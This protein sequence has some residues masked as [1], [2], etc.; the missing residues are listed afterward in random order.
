MLRSKTE[1][2]HSTKKPRHYNAFWVLRC[3]H[4]AKKLL[5]I[6]FE[7]NKDPIICKCYCTD[8]ILWFLIHLYIYLFTVNERVVSISERATTRISHCDWISKTRTR[9]G[10]FAERA[11][12][13]FEPNIHTQACH[14]VTCRIMHY[15]GYCQRIFLTKEWLDFVVPFGSRPTFVSVTTMIR[16]R[17]ST[18]PSTRVLPFFHFR[19]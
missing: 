2:V 7:L 19:K 17:E 10:S 16:H 12:S 8:F 9:C 14:N 18:S 15:N 3:S 6:W 4:N 1:N 11:F 13:I 5:W